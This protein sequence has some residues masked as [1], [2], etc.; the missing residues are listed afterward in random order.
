VCP[1]SG[2]IPLDQVVEAFSKRPKPVLLEDMENEAAAY[3]I[4]KNGAA[5]ENRTHA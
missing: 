2:K 5:Y 1:N 4:E 3:L